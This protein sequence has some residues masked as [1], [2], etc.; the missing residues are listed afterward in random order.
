MLRPRMRPSDL[1]RAL[2]VSAESVSG[3]MSGKSLPTIKHMVQIEKI[4]GIP[5]KSWAEDSTSPSTE[6][7]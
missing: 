7:E 5:L 2:D 1:A 3:W 6:K 4:L